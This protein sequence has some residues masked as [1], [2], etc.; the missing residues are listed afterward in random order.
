MTLPRVLV[1]GASGFVGRAVAERFAREG[2][3]VRAPIRKP[4]AILPVG[5][6]CVRGADLDPASD[7]RGALAGVDIIVHCAARV[8]VMRE[9]DLDPLA[10]FRHV[11]VG[12]TLKLAR[13]AA[14]VGVHRL[15]FIS[16]IGVN[17]NETR[18]RP[19]T[20][21]DDPAP[22]SAYAESKCEAEISLRNL[23]AETGLEVV[24]IRPPLVYGPGAPGNFNRLLRAL[25]RGIPMPF[26]AIVD[27]QRS[28]VALG[29]LVDLI[30]IATR[31]PS[32]ANQT[33]LVSDG[34]DVSTAQLLIKASHA[35]GKQARLVVVPVWALR[36]AAALVG[37]RDLAQQL[38]GS[39]QID[40]SPT[41]SLLNWN[42]PIAFDDAIRDAA[43]HFLNELPKLD[44]VP[45]TR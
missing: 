42:P 11:N 44:S 17:G 29:N 28:L 31:H 37:K 15:I 3:S 12:G 20:A 34:S 25:H 24:I 5:V 7:W 43:Q 16:S 27:N 4:T 10:A 39:L 23:A 2:H 41:R 30:V 19:F 22:H 1:T 9:S 18:G 6:E 14:E 8:H 32:A 35:I 45:R 36:S 26:G 38:C 13:Q 33:I 40:I 21:T